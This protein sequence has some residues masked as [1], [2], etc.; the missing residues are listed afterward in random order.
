MNNNAKLIAKFTPFDLIIYLLMF[1]SIF[2]QRFAVPFGGTQI[3]L[4]MPIMLGLTIIYIIKYNF[5]ISLIRLLLFGLF[6]LIVSFITFFHESV[7]YFSLLYLIALYVPFLINFNID[8][9]NK[10]KY[11]KILQNTI[12]FTA[13]IGIFQFILQIV[14]IGF[15]DPISLLPEHI[16]QQGYLTTYSI[17]YGSEIMKSN[18][19]FFL[20]PSLF[21]QFLAISIIIELLLFKRWFRVGLLGIAIL[22]TFSGTG[23]LLLAFVALPIIFTLKPKQATSI[24]VLGFVVAFIFF[25]SEYGETTLSRSQEYK[26]SN[27]SFSIRFIN[28]FKAVM[29]SDNSKI[30]F[31]H[32]AG[33]S[34]LA[35]FN[36]P[37]N[38]T[39]IPKLWYEYGFI[40]MILFLLFII[41]YLVNKRN[42]VISVAILF[43]YLFLSG[44]LLQP[45][46]IL[47]VFIAGNILGIKKYDLLNI[48]RQRKSRIIVTKNLDI[49]LIKSSEITSE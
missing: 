13:I 45:Q 6:L 17:S 8:L 31:G 37:T 30:V 43:M 25:T 1:T 42:K 20:E 11:L 2:L 24:L 34:D 27:S 47:F 48:T 7:S 23:L 28:P 46:T 33:Q 10:V 5:K 36:Y 32:G 26:S 29:E 12:L 19:T 35:I 38:F 49:K 44:S 40:P 22:F 16:L 4:A 21:S 15:F 18:G 9:Q 14:G 39:V 41:N 3:P